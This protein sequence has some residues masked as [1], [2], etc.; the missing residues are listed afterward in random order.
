MKRII[1]EQSGVNS[2]TYTVKQV[3]ERIDVKM[4]QQELLEEVCCLG[5]DKVSELLVNLLFG[6]KMFRI[7]DCLEKDTLCKL[8]YDNQIFYENG[9]DIEEIEDLDEND[10]FKIS[11]GKQFNI[12]E[13]KL[14]KNNSIDLEGELQGIGIST[15]DDYETER[16]ISKYE[17]RLPDLS[18]CENSECRYL[19]IPE[20][21]QVVVSADSQRD[22]LSSHFTTTGDN[23][24]VQDMSITNEINRITYEPDCIFYSD[25][26][27]NWPIRYYTIARPNKNQLRNFHKWVGSIYSA[28]KSKDIKRLQ[29]GRKAFWKKYFQIKKLNQLSDWMF[30]YQVSIIANYFDTCLGIKK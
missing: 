15:R 25:P 22:N 17:Y 10:L 7:E 13:I 28:N 20:L 5:I 29:V 23:P 16:M 2:G 30:K 21:I 24:V 19:D 4:F 26:N 18:E 14:N 27:F 11:V 1:V 6:Q 3:T 12:E 9:I 8:V